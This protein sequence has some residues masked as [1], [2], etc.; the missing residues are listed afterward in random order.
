MKFKYQVEGVSGDG[1]TNEEEFRAFAQCNELTMAMKIMD[2]YQKTYP[3][4]AIWIVKYNEQ[5]DVWDE[6]SLREV[7]TI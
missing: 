6:I 3:T 5:E 4:F 2:F 1:D 7:A